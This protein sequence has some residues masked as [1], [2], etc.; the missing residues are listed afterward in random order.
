M[1]VHWRRGQLNLRYCA[2][3]WPTAWYVKPT[4]FEHPDVSYELETENNK[5]YGP[6]LLLR[7]SDRL[8]F[9]PLLRQM[10]CRVF[11]DPFKLRYGSQCRV[12]QQQGPWIPWGLTF[13]CDQPNVHGRSWAD[14]PV[15]RDYTQPFSFALF[16][17]ALGFN[18]EGLTLRRIAALTETASA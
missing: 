13:P 8:I 2:L 6:W 15:V 4:C 12:Q 14:N 16:M 3:F 9:I 1:L 7:V 11:F 18:T 5:K 10:G 17:R